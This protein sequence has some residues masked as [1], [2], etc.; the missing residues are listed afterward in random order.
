M[1]KNWHYD[2]DQILTEF[3]EATEKDQKNSKRNKKTGAI[4]KEV[5]TSRIEMLEAHAKDKLEN[6]SWYEFVSI[7]FDKLLECWK[8]PDPRDAFYLAVF[9]KTFA[10]KQHEQE[11][12]FDD[13]PKPRSGGPAEIKL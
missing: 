12:D 2:K 11:M 1:S 7:N 8:A 5:Y 4:T 3:K 6:P 9:G 10:E 13:E